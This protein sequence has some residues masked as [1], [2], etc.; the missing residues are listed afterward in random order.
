VVHTTSCTKGILVPGKLSQVVLSAPAQTFQRL[1]IPRVLK[2]Q[3]FTSKNPSKEPDVCPS[4]EQK[5]FLK[6]HRPTFKLSTLINLIMGPQPPR[7]TSRDIARP[8]LKFA[9]KP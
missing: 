8:G 3:M 7:A 6:N 5:S 2:S 9:S 4:F 1:K